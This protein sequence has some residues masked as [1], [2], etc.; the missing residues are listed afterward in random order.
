MSLRGSE[1][2]H[3]R[4]VDA[5]PATGLIRLHYGFA[6]G[7]EFVEEVELPPGG[8][9]RRP[10]FDAAARLLLLLAGT[11]YYKSRAPGSVVV[12]VP[13][14]LAERDLVT[15]VYDHGLREFAYTNRLPIPLVDRFD[16][17]GGLVEA[18]RPGPIP[19]AIER[20]LIPFG[21]GKDSTVVMTLVPEGQPVTVNPTTTHHRAA[22]VLG[23]DLISVRRRIDRLDELTSS[24]RLNGHVP[25]TAVIS[26]IALL[27]AARDGY[28][29][30]VMANE[31]AASEPTLW[32]GPS[33]LPV[34]HQWSKSADFE[35]LMR[36]A[37]ADGGVGVGYFSLLRSMSE[38]QIISI[39]SGRREVLPY[40]LSCNR[41][42]AGRTA[43]SADEAPQQWCGE[44]PKCLFTFLLLATELEPEELVG[45]FGADLLDLDERSGG[46]EALW[47]PEKP[48]ECIGERADAALAMTRLAADPRWAAHTVVARLAES[49]RQVLTEAPEPDVAD[50]GDGIPA[51]FRSRLTPVVR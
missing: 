21:G 23:R 33:G 38:Q 35:L 43:G 30:V 8:P 11:S 13:T 19:E 22:A 2:F 31:A 29:A 25:I 37:I 42:F 12:E 15:A 6:G 5:D 4:H 39:L 7:P 27:L 10:G 50:S 40:L 20:P 18:A 16:W 36:N 28:S 32:T 24:N 45:I 26:A 49:A 44:C 17:A 3:I 51:A 48:F 1:P 34:N 14:T 47:A 46:F 9:D 41:A